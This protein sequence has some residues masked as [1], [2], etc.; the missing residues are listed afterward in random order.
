MPRRWLAFAFGCGLSL[1]SPLLWAFGSAHGIEGFRVLDPTRYQ[2]FSE[3]GVGAFNLI[4]QRQ[5]LHS[6]CFFYGV[7][8][9]FQHLE[10]V[11]IAAAT[12]QG[13]QKLLDFTIHNGC[14]EFR[15]D[16]AEDLP[17]QIEFSDLRR[18]DG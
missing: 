1:F 3:R 15:F 16:D 13:D 11:T 12:R 17:L 14:V 5:A 6:V 10:G 4:G 7:E 2:V 8:K 18:S 9:P